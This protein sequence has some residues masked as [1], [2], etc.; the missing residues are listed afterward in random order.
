MSCAGSNDIVINIKSTV[1][2]F[3][4]DTSLYLIVDEPVE[5]ARCLN[6]DLELIY[7]RAER[8]L[9]KLN[10]AK[11]ESLL[12]SRKANKSY[13]PPLLMNNEPI[14]DVTSHKHVLGIFLSS[15]GTWHEHINYIMLCVSLNLNLTD[16]H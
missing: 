3:A 12:I 13:H 14:K 11:S 15:D 7:Q 16:A 8:W 1:R 9:V 4:D 6:S 2:F 10:A 5:T